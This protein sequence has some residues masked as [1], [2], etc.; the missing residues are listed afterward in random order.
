MARKPILC[1]D[2]DGV[3]HGYQSGWQGAAIIPDPA[4]PG[5]V[6]FLHSAV[7][8]FQVVIYSSRSGQPGGIDAMRGWLMMNLMAV[9]EDRREA[10]HVLSQIQWATEKPA[11]MVTLDDRAIT[12]D[13]YW[14]SMDALAAF[15]PW[16]KRKASVEPYHA[17]HRRPI[18]TAP[19][20]EEVYVY[21]GEMRFRAKLVSGASAYEDDNG[22][23]RICDQWQATR[24]GEHPPCWSEGGCWASN[25]DESPSLQPTHWSPAPAL[26]PGA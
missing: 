7:E 14:P 10:D 20:D 26:T 8:R 19:L 23:E 3:L 4:V 1:L 9:I 5:A 13:G 6:G 15:Q 21:C 16:N 2:F 24:D 25:A 17:D 12:F 22:R 18:N 11:A